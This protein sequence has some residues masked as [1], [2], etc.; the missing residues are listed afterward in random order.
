MSPLP[1]VRRQVRQ[2]LAPGLIAGLIGGIAFGAAMAELG[3]LPTV[4]SLVRTDSPLVGFVVHMAIAAI[5]GSGLAVL[6]RGR[7]TAGDVV[8]WGVAY[9][10]FLWF[11]GPIT[12]QPLIL[13]QLPT[14]DLA[15]A[16]AAYPSLLGHIVWGAA[17]G[18]SLVA[19][20][21]RAAF[22]DTT[23]TPRSEP[24]QA[25][26]RGVVLRGLVA[27]L[28]GFGTIGMLP[29]GS[30]RMFLPWGGDDAAGLE[31]LAVALLGSIVY[32]VL[33]PGS[34][35]TAGGAAVRG[36]GFGFILWVI[37]GLTLLPLLRGEGLTWSITDARTTFP[38]LPG[39][40]LFGAAMA[41]I[42]HWLGRLTRL[43]F[44]DD[45]GNRSPD[46]GSWG[47]R[48]VGRGAAAGI[49]GGVLFTLVMVRIGYLPTV[50]KLVGSDSELVGLGVHLL[51]AEIVGV[52]YGVLFRRQAFDQSA[53]IGWGVSYGFLW[54]VLGPLTLAPVILGTSPAWTVEAAASAFPSLI[55]HLAYG[56]GLG[57]T[58]HAMEA[59]YS[60]WWITRTDA[61]ATRM[62]GRRVEASSAGPAIWALLVLVA[63]LLPV[64]LSP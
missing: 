31:P 61:E 34:T 41:L 40:I 59:R 46:A 14:W 17:T 38:A 63:V 26:L 6:L 22:V 49:V 24:P 43:F 23:T 48:A 55:G 12:M 2:T 7:W 39:T 47:P 29:G 10:A 11:V 20:K 51:I 1:D 9:G 32:A 56:A 33:H 16:Q 5:L 54:W 62:A 19:I 44:S 15:A 27:G 8:L 37:G 53:A 45:V 25:R 57:L 28:L 35:S 50:A 3:V 21:G 52:S 30:E 58:F 13:G 4:A 42:Y 64:V 60:P 36:A 18:L